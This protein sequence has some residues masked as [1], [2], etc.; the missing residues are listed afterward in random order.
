[1]NLN[2]NGFEIE[3]GSNKPY[4]SI[5]QF[6][7]E[8]KKEARESSAKWKAKKT[9]SGNYQFRFAKKSSKAKN[10]ISR[11][12]RIGAH[13]ILMPARPYLVVQQEDLNLIS[14]KFLEFL[15]TRV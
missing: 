13:S 14:T 5:H 3:M 8:I 15:A 10:T 11:G 6:G 9:A 1:M 4:A 12:F 2:G 7:G